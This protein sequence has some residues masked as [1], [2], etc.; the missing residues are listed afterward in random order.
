MSD[1]TLVYGFNAVAAVLRY[2]ATSIKLLYYDQRSSNPRLTALVQSASQQGI[3]THAVNKAELQRLSNKARHQGVV[4]EQ[5]RTTKH[6]QQ[7]DLEVLLKA[8][9]KPLLLVLDGV[10]D[11][12]NLGA[13]WRTAAAAGVTAIVIPADR[14]VGVT[15]TVRK[16][17]SG[18]VETTP[19]IQVKNLAR[20]LKTLQ[21][22]GIWLIG[23]AADAPATL[24]E[25]DFTSS[26]AIIMGAEGSGL[27]RLTREHCDGL[28]RIPI[29]N[30]IESLNVSVATGVMLFEAHRQR[31]LASPPA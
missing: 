26:T 20:T 5:I 10:Q 17:A 13:C 28:V 24:Y 11:P 23:A 19:L 15:A 3:N 8:T 12:H 9:D 25:T 1:T 16:V 22:H 27:R 29:S 14:A 31:M 18:A 2:E 6:Y 21:Q 7:A 4:V 30:T